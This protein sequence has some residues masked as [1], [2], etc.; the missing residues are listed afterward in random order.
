[1]G[2]VWFTADTH[3]NHARILDL[4]DRPFDTVEAMNECLIENWNATVSPADTVWHLGDVGMGDADRNLALVDKL[5]GTKH[6][7]AGNHDPVWPGNRHAHRHQRE[8]LAHFASVQAFARYTVAGQTVLLSHFP[9]TGDHGS[10]DRY[11][12]FRLRD[13]GLW[14]IHGHV[15]EQWRR[16]GRQ[17]N[18]GVEVR[19]YRPVSLDDLTETIITS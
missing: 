4:A 8:W 5:N 3:F 1:M 19:E 9:Y 15:H 6:L 16:R 7:V 18:V 17:L 10:V 12:E 14:L 11:P 2:E 13:T